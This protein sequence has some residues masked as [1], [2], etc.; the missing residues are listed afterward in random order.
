MI[1]NLEEEYMLKTR[2]MALLKSIYTL[3]LLLL[4]TGCTNKILY[5]PQKVTEE[6]ETKYPYEEKTLLTKDGE[7]LSAI[8]YH[9]AQNKNRSVVLFLYG[10]ADN[11]NNCSSLSTTFVPRGYDFFVVDYRGYGKSTGSPT[12]E[13]I[14]IDIQ[15]TIE[16]LSKNF[17]NIYIYGQSIGAVSLLGILDEIEKEKIRAIVSE[18]AFLSYKELSKEFLGI[19]LPW[20]DYDTLEDYAP[21]SSN[22]ETKIPLLLIHSEEDNLISYKQG[23]SLAKHFKYAK[24]RKT[25]GNHL[26]FLRSYEH[27]EEIFDFFEKRRF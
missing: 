26:G 25:K 5:M 9:S 23:L 1:K 17:E 6:I 7:K 19:E 3:I 11:L 10:N 8:E 14:K 13:G 18:G 24:H 16:Y 22:R 2:G 27:F 15:T 20:I 4:F 12:P 21:I